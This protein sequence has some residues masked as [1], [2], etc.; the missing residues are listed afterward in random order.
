MILKIL[1]CGTST[2]VPLPACGCSVCTSGDPRN[3]RLRT[4]ALIKIDSTA[5]ILIDAS[6]DLR[7]QALKWKIMNIS[8]VLFTHHHADHILGM[9]DLRGFNFVQK[10]AINCYAVPHTARR[11]KRVFSYAFHSSRQYE[12]GAPP[13]LI[14]NEI[15]YVSPFA[16]TGLTVQPFPLLHG[17]MRIVGYRI[18][19]MAYAT[20]C[21]I[22]PAE[23]L[24]LLRGVKLFI[25]DGLRH[26][27]HRT[28]QTISEAIA[29][30]RSVGAQKTYLTHLT[31]TV[32]YEPTSRSLPPGI[33]LA[34]DGLE[35]EFS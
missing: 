4:S 1:G 9:D 32:D 26:E 14:M 34:Y 11:I 8:A 13:Q 5:N 31:H 6:P 33:E 7:Q 35:I 12:G 18:G 22:I 15:D 27:Q 30:A 17:S 20:D 23:T 19:D 3:Q 10:G 2:G 29:V 21:K 25:L 28:H 24:E 16:V